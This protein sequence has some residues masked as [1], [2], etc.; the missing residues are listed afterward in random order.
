MK[1]KKSQNTVSLWRIGTTVLF[2]SCL[3]KRTININ[4]YQQSCRV[5]VLSPRIEATNLL[6]LKFINYVISSSTTT[7]EVHF[8][9]YL[10]IGLINVTPQY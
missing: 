8:E 7:F 6:L 5:I 10:G 4:V 3:V 1:S 2:L 9:T